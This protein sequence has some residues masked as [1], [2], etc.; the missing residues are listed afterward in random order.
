MPHSLGADAKGTVL[1]SFM[2]EGYHNED[3][4]RPE[5]LPTQVHASFYESVVSS[6]WVRLDSADPKGPY[7]PYRLEVHSGARL[8]GACLL[9]AVATKQPRA[10]TLLDRPS[11]PQLASEGPMHADRLCNNFSSRALLFC[12]PPP[13]LDKSSSLNHP[14]TNVANV[15]APPCM[16]WRRSSCKSGEVLPGGLVM[17]EVLDGP[18]VFKDNDHLLNILACRLCGKWAT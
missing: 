14:K 6:V 5:Q 2:A 1:H 13:E 8:L 10:Y 3:C 18:V 15:G 17:S 12:T 7:V 16:V 4:L 9:P 11:R